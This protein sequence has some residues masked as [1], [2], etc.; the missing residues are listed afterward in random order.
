MGRKH[1]KE[2]GF[3][4][5]DALR[6]VQLPEK[7]QVAVVAD[8]LI[9]SDAGLNGYVDGAYAIA[10]LLS[11]SESGVD[12]VAS[13]IVHETN[14][15]LRIKTERMAARRRLRDASRMGSQLDPS[16]RVNRLCRSVFGPADQWV[17]VVRQTI[18]I[19][20]PHYL[21]FHK[22][23]DGVRVAGFDGFIV[24]ELVC[25]FTFKEN[26]GPT[27]F[28]LLPSKAKNISDL[29]VHL[30]LHP[31]LLSNSDVKVEWCKRAFLV[32]GNNY[33]PWVYP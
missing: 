22:T 25:G 21:W 28:G 24:D 4:V 14:R 30:G 10:S 3:T 23:S 9:T 26:T 17:S 5:L 27:R 18:K 29:M 15:Q 2:L 1:R 13:A 19:R 12:R 31:K 20:D 11:D 16:I 6:L 8:F 32:S 33:L 7:H